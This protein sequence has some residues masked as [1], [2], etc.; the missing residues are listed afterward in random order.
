MDLGQVICLFK[1]LSFSY[2]KKFYKKY[3]YKEKYYIKGKLFRPPKSPPNF[4]AIFS[5]ISM[6]CETPLPFYLPHSREGIHFVTSLGDGY[7]IA[8]DWVQALPNPSS[9]QLVYNIYYSTLPE[10][11]FSEGIKTVSVT[12]DVIAGTLYEFT[13]GDIYFFAVRAS[14]FDPSWGNLNLLQDGF[15]GFKIYP[16]SILLNNITATTLNIPVSDI[17]LWPPTGIAQIGDELIKYSS[18]DIPNN[19]LIVASLNDRGFLNTPVTIHNI[20]GYDGYEIEESPLVLFFKGFEEQNTVIFQATS[21]FKDGNYAFTNADGYRI[22]TKDNLTTDLDA[23]DAAQIGFTIL[24]HSGWH[25]TNPSALLAGECV[26]TYIGGEQFCADGYGVGF[27]IRG[28][29]FDQENDRRLEELL[30]IDGQRV[31]LVKR[32]WKG[33]TCSCFE[34]SHQNPALRCPRCYGT[35]F[36]TG[37][38]Q[39]FNPRESD[40]RI[41]VK[42][43]PTEDSTKINDEGLESTF[44]PDSWSLSVP[45]IKNRDFIIRFNLDGSEEFRY[46]ILSV[47]RNVLLNSLSGAQKFKLQRIR[48]TDPIYMWKYISNTSTIPQTLS[49]GVG[50]LAG[51]NGTLIPHVHT[52]VV[53]EKITSLS[54]INQTTSISLGHNHIVKNGLIVQDETNIGHSHMILL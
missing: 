11:V 36:V 46:K 9:Y 41:L 12:P 29:P 42:F 16:E 10:H 18:R 49:T 28:V 3:Y 53:S 52:I 5:H 40:G 50:F 2:F 35:G 26:G 17:S 19:Y 51:P 47:T 23:N 22:T 39:Y 43:G 6:V 44:L 33:L 31:V 45:T 32:L 54:Q 20:D 14:L 34:P 24:D 13:S 38:D 1:N 15:P 27:Q 8:L 37:Y 48:K 30:T 21:T 25:R 4:K 7:G